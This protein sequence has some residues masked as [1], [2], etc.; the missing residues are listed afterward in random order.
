M[1]FV[2]ITRLRIRSWRFLPAF[3]WHAVR[4]QAQVTRAEGFT[5]GSLLRDRR[6]TFWTMML[7]RDSAVMRQYMTR[8]AHLRAMPK[9]LEWCDEASVVHWQQDGGD[10]P[11][12]AEANRR[13]RA[14]GRPSK[15]RH[16]STAHAALAYRAP[17]LS[18]AVPMRARR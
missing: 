3:F 7:W 2:S 4:S 13:M 14:E 1:T 5:A 16:P 6:F 15:V 9:L 17:R 8:G 10:L 11:D 12:W 18:G